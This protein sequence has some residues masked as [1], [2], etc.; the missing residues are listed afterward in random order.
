MVDRYY[1]KIEIVE[2]NIE[3]SLQIASILLKLKEFDEKLNDISKIN[4]NSNDISSNLEKIDENR[5]NLYAKLKK[6]I[7]DKTFIIE[8]IT[9]A[10]NIKKICDIY[11]KSTFTINEIIK[12]V[13]NY[14]YVYDGNDNFSHLYKFYSNGSKFKEIKIDHDRTLNTVNHNFE[15]KSIDSSKINIVIYLI[16][17]NNSN[18]E[19]FGYNTLQIIYNDYIKILRI[20]GDKENISAHLEKIDENKENIASNLEKIDENKENISANLEKIDENKEDIAS[21]LEKMNNISDIKIFEGD[22]FY[23]LKEIHLIDLNFVKT[24][25]ID[26]GNIE[27][28]VHQAIIDYKFNVGN[29]LQ[30]NESI[31]FNF[32]NLR[33][34]LN[35]IKEHYII[36]N[37]ND[38]IIYDFLYNVSSRGNIARNSYIFKNKNLFNLTQI[39]QS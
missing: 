29:F 37:E 14:N 23:I 34:E 30:L 38:D 9:S 25:K 16:N 7:Y 22:D 15:I 26:I 10:Y 11:I 2:N 20:D 1:K 24:L 28:L 17:N 18:V 5:S 36:K 8:N 19:L 6:D 39:Y 31:Y 12:I 13:G 3:N 4:D 33:V 32:D 27:V 21:N 35:L